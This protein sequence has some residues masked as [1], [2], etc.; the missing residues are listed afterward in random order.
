MMQATSSLKLPQ[1]E[2]VLAVKQE[3]KNDSSLGCRSL[4]RLRKQLVRGAF[5]PGLANK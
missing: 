1:K 5:N 2:E 3:I 4:S